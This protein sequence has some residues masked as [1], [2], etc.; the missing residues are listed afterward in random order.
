VA[1]R[2]IPLEPLPPARAAARPPAELASHR[3]TGDDGHVW[4]DDYAAALDV[5]RWSGRPLFLF[6]DHPSCPICTAYHADHFRDGDV[7][8]A[9]D[10]FVLA[11]FNAMRVPPD[12][13]RLLPRA[14][15]IRVVVDAG[16]KRVGEL[17][18]VV[19][20]TG[21]A[22]W[23]RGE[24]E[25]R[26]GAPLDWETVRTLAGKLIEAERETDP[27]RRLALWD[28]VAAADPV[29]PFGR[30]A[31]DHRAALAYDAQ[32]ALFEAQAAATAEAACAALA[33]GLEATRG[34]PRGAD[35]AAVLQT[36]ETKGAFPR[37][38]IER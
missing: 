31:K 13:A 14:W 12:V 5:A 24:S 3:V 21:L 38:E 11:S 22:A 17:T 19:D 10:G 16:G 23:L 6:V 29:G 1:L 4:M 33:R 15:P 7:A 18:R 2:A 28:E 32:Q 27:A 9:A 8:K 30:A 34:T 26:E 20:A 25:R 37:L 36:M 35:L